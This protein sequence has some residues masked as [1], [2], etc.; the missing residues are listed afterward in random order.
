MPHAC[1]CSAPPCPA[2]RRRRTCTQQYEV[3]AQPFLHVIFM[4]EFC[5][6]GGLGALLVAAAS[7]GMLVAALP[8]AVPA[9]F[10]L[11]LR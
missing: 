6:W 9:Y 8:L 7:K 10:L 2:G 4:L 5:L 11:K 3:G 1:L